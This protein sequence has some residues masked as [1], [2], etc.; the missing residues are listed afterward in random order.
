VNDLLRVLRDQGRTAEIRPLVAERLAQLQRVAERADAGALALYRYAW[1]LL[2]CEA[3]DLRNAAAALPVAQRAVELDGGQ[4]TAYLETLAQAHRMIGDLDQ[5]IEVQR[6]AMAQA[7]AGGPYNRAE[8]EAR[9]VDYL[10]EK[11]DLVAVASLSW[12]GLAA[13]FGDSLIPYSDPAAPAVAQSEALMQEGRFEEAANILRACLT[14]RQKVL[15]EGNW[16]IADTLSRLG[17]ATAGEGDF[18]EAERL[19]LEAH[20]AIKDNR[21]APE[22]RK[23][24][25]VERIIRLYESWDRPDQASEWRQRLEESAED[26]E[27]KA[28]SLDIR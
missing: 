28:Q 7:R 27:T 8:L 24:Q 2:N 21:W 25:A 10:M 23:S 16:L 20:A 12:E 11:R 4:D 22:D 14:A 15:P 1:E 3:V 18:A 17:S 19:L 26:L 5:A 9:L 13:R 6:R